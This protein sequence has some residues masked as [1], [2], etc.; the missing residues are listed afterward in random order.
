MPFK[1]TLYFTDDESVV[2]TTEASSLEKAIE[3]ISR[4]IENKKVIVKLEGHYAKGY[5]LANV[6]QFH[7][8]AK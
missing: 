7:I 6:R 1:V 2:I 5:N 8:S 3:E 4:M